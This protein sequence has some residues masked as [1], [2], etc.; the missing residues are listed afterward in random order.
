[1]K[2][3]PASSNLDAAN[4]KALGRLAAAIQLCYNSPSSLS[5][6]RRQEGWEKWIFPLYWG[7]AAQSAF[8]VVEFHSG[9]DTLP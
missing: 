8:I 4:D 1:M 5:L 3:L 9:V 7:T 2:A 6:F